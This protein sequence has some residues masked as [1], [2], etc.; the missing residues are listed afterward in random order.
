[1][2]HIHHFV[3]CSELELENRALLC[4]RPNP[5]ATC[6]FMP[7]PLLFLSRA[8]AFAFFNLPIYYACTTHLLLC[9]ILLVTR[10]GIQLIVGNETDQLSPNPPVR[11]RPPM[12]APCPRVVTYQLTYSSSPPPCHQRK[13]LEL[14]VSRL[15]SAIAVRRTGPCPCCHRG[16]PGY[17]QILARL[18][19]EL[20]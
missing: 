12:A 11:A 1:M 15:G 8:G 7:L 18:T 6:L 10:N 3:H 14:L 13:K 9:L 20:T 4:A 5:F 16:H 2:S 19:I 17:H